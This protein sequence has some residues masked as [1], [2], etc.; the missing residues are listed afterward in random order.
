VRPSSGIAE[1][2]DLIE[3]NLRLANPKKFSRDLAT[4]ID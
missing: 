4:Q 1:V 3:G 2:D